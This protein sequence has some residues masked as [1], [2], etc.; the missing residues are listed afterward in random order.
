[1]AAVI[2]MVARGGG[3]V[4]RARLAG[5]RSRGSGSQG[6]ILSPVRR[7]PRPLLEESVGPRALGIGLER[8]QRSSRFPAAAPRH[9]A[10]FGGGIV[11]PLASGARCPANPQPRS[12][13]SADLRYYTS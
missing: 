4:S 13:C 2:E 8:I 6:L 1:M 5:L 11:P 3:F 7:V 10:A 9:P 12:P